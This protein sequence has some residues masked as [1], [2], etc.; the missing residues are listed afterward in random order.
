MNKKQELLEIL[1]NPRGKTIAVDL[2]DTLC[3]GQFWGEGEP[4]PIQERID[5]IWELYKKGAIILIYT[6]RAPKWFEATNAWLLKHGV[7]FHGINMMRKPGACLYIDDRALNV[8]DV[9]E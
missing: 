8:D 4:E 3:H 6:A 1:K 2:D 5:Y 7:P 9:W